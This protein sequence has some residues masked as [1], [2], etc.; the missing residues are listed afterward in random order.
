MYAIIRFLVDHLIQHTYRL[1]AINNIQVLTDMV[2]NTT[3]L[4]KQ[5]EFMIVVPDSGFGSGWLL[6]H[7]IT[8][9]IATHDK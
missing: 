9:L 8:Q 1:E 6:T 4:L 7:N 5:E 2:K 3:K